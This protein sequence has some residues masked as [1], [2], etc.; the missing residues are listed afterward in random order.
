[1]RSI[2]K[3][4]EGMRKSAGF[5]NEI[6]KGNLDT[7]FHALSDGDMLG[8][9]LLTM[10]ENLKKVDEEDRKRNW[11]TK[12]LAMFG[13]I[14]RSNNNDI[15]GLSAAIISNLVKYLNANQGGL[16]LLNDENKNEIFLE[17]KACYAYER[18]KFLEKAIFL[19]EGLVGQCWQEKESIYLTDVPDNYLNI[20]SGLGN[21]NPRNVLIVPLKVN[22]AIFG[23]IELAAFDFIENHEVEFVEKMAESIASTISSV[24]VNMR[25]S[26][27]LEESQRLSGELQTQEEEM[28]QNM[29][30]LKATQE[31]MENQE[32]VLK[33]KLELAEQEI[34]HL[35]NGKSH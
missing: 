25:T 18:K 9:S 30:E 12:G 15:E 21:A 6:G 10:R 26:K 4:I 3:L 20:T 7:E 24:K 31:A 22:D 27:L 29:E 1:M 16:F 8:I 35:K 23:V 5:A 17:L 32:H 28:R 14:L 19:G 11:A 2:K 13:E 34:L 33:S